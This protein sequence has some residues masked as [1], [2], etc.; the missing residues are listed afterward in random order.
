[1]CENN[2]KWIEDKTTVTLERGLV[3]HMQQ[4]MDWGESYNDY[5]QSELGFED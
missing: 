2:S 1:M 4:N 5:L 3:E